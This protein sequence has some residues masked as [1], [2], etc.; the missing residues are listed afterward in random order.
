LPGHPP[1]LHLF[2]GLSTVTSSSCCGRCSGFPQVWHS[3]L[4]HFDGLRDGLERPPGLPRLLGSP[5]WLRFRTPLQHVLIVGAMACGAPRHPF[6]FPL[7]RSLPR[8]RPTNCHSPAAL[9]CSLQSDFVTLSCPVDEKCLSARPLSLAFRPQ[10]N[11]PPGASD[12]FSFFCPPQFF[13]LPP[14]PPLE[15]FMDIGGN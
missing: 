4:V 7:I 8:S 10:P 12:D 13:V 2:A 6:L 15:P 9:L 1:Q 14:I 11:P 5:L 3:P